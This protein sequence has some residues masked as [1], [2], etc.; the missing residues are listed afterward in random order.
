MDEYVAVPVVNYR[1]QLKLCAFVVPPALGTPGGASQGHQGR[2]GPGRD[3]DILRT[4][5][6]SLAMSI[7][8]DGLFYADAGRSS[9]YSLITVGFLHVNS[10]SIENTSDAWRHP[11]RAP[12]DSAHY[13][14]I[15]CAALSLFLIWYAECH[16]RMLVVAYTCWLL[17]RLSTPSPSCRASL[18]AIM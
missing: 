16:H 11:S 8:C 5:C 1:D 13:P 2:S 15:L 3:V 17:F 12:V 7:V 10:L 6:C 18:F 9:T 14:S 4:R